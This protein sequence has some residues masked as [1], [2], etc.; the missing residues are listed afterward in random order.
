MAFCRWLSERTGGRS[1]CRP[2][3]NGNRPAV[4]ARTRP[5]RYGEPG[6]RLLAVGQSGRSA[7]RCTG[8]QI[9]G[10]LEHMMLEGALLSDARFDDGAVVTAPVGSYRPNA[11][12]LHDLHGNAAEWTRSTYRP[13]PY[14]EDDGAKRRIPRTAKWSAAVPS[15]IRPAVAAARSGWTIRPG[16]ACSTW[17]FA[18]CWTWIK[19]EHQVRD[20]SFRLWPFRLWPSSRSVAGRRIFPVPSA[21]HARSAPDGR[22]VGVRILA[23]LRILGQRSSQFSHRL[24][25]G[26]RGADVAQLERV[27]IEIEQARVA[28]TGDDELVA[29]G[30]GHQPVAVGIPGEGHVLPGRRRLA[31]AKQGGGVAAF[32]AAV[33][34]QRPSARG[35]WA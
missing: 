32:V 5:C 24:A 20:D 29:A 26:R 33:A 22:L 30:H 28:V 15:L 8:K 6:R 14:R 34:R 23:P 17:A 31:G 35:S 9:T 1:V 25:R 12:G 7:V 2:R 21:A 27:G 10:G 13:Y 19:V 16:N 4:P 11:W 18:S 3:P